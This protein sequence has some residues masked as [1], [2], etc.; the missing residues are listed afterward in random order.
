MKRN[1]NIIVLGSTGFIGKVIFDHLLKVFK[2]ENVIGFSSKSCDLLKISTVKKKLSGLKKNDIL[3]IAS[4]IARA[5]ENSLDSMQRNILMVENI[6]KILNQKPVAQVIYLSSVDVYGVKKK[7]KNDTQLRKKVIDENSSLFIDD[8]YSMGKIISEFL[9]KNQSLASRFVLTVLR[10]P[11]VYG[12]S[13]KQ[14]SL[15]GLFAKKILGE[16]F[17]EIEGKG[18]ILRNYVCVEDVAQIVEKCIKQKEQGI[19]NIVSEKSLSILAIAKI[20]K[21][22]LSPKAKIKFKD[23]TSSSRERNRDILFNNKRLISAFKKNAVRTMESGIKE[24]ALSYKN[25]C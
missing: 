21:K 3:I 20:L 24:Y 13:D 11:G 4:S 9:L 15:V 12:L 18:Q 10:F 7:D 5:S 6:T 14:K 22:S 2:K 25:E 8:Y 23:I 16:G 17:L 19:F 1:R